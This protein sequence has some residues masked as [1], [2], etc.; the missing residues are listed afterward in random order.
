[1]KNCV[2][3]TIANNKIV[4]TMRLE[5]WCGYQKLLGITYHLKYSWKE[6]RQTPLVEMEDMHPRKRN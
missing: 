6:C 1:M 2:K 4:D 5:V 3:A